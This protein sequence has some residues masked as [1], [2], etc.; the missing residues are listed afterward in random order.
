V[1]WMKK[2][3]M[4]ITALVILGVLAFGSIL[5]YLCHMEANLPPAQGY[6]AIIV[7]GAQVLPTMVPSVQL[8]YRLEA[9]LKAYNDDPCILVTCGAKGGD[10]PMAEADF[11]KDWLI[12][13]DV[14]ED[15]ILTES[16]S[17][18][19]RENI[20][21]AIALLEGRG[22]TK[23]LI[24]TSDYHLPRAMALAN[25]QGMSATGLGS[26]CKNDIMNWS[27]NHFRETL[28]WCKYWAEKHFGI[29][30]S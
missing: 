19:T 2:L 13:N 25:D 4:V 9:A 8:Q 11:M 18:N 22:T 26:P 15:M 12:Q 17:F 28:A 7:L 30:L 10:E 29:R 21:N 14:P 23:A 6:D 5:L 24:V 16:T 27:R 3:A 20:E 1:K